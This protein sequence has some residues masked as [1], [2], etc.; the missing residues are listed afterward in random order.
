M[1]PT[2]LT[3]FT[4]ASTSSLRMLPVVY[5]I[6]ESSSVIP[7]GADLH[8]GP[9]V[10]SVHC[11]GHLLRDRS[12]INTDAPDEMPRERLFDK[13]L[14]LLAFLHLPRNADPSPAIGCHCIPS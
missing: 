11:S 4:S 14:G 7:V 5:L 10:R 6:I 8:R 2:Q 9:M 12:R 1:M 13:K 3:V